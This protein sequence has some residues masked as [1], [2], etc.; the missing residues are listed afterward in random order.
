M[1]PKSREAPLA[2]CGRIELVRA[3]V[4]ERGL[5]FDVMRAVRI[6]LVYADRKIEVVARV[7]KR[8][9]ERQA[10]IGPQVL[11]R[12][13]TDVAILIVAKLRQRLGQRLVGGL[14]GRGGELLRAPGDVVKSERGRPGREQRS[15][16]EQK[17]VGRAN[18]KRR[19]I[20][21]AG[22][23]TPER[24][25]RRAGDRSCARHGTGDSCVS[26][27]V[28]T[29]SGPEKQTPE[30]VPPEDIAIEP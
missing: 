23:G 7:K 27:I 15:D 4:E 25:Q 11:V 16:Q 10:G 29:V 18:M 22:G 1:D 21:R 5:V 13:K 30:T 9:L 12:T 24:A 26:E 28:R 2:Q 6:D 3:V 8:D 19:R 17:R 14:V 20:P